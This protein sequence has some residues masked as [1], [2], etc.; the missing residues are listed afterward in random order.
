MLGHTGYLS[1]V[2]EWSS[3]EQSGAL[4]VF[5]YTMFGLFMTVHTDVSQINFDAACH[6]P[7]RISQDNQMK[8]GVA[9]KKPLL[10]QWK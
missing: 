5:K 8:L 2:V 10:K 9:P 1:L 6:S 4:V 3:I 7:L